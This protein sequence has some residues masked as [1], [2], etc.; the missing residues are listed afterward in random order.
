MR[1][2]STSVTNLKRN[3]IMWVL[4]A[5]FR[6]LIFSAAA[7]W[8][9]A[10]LSFYVNGLRDANLQS[11]KQFVYARGGAAANYI[12]HIDRT[13]KIIGFAALIVHVWRQ[14]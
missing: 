8:V 7:I 5:I 14:F 12:N 3:K 11:F 1:L 9:G 13:I 2:T 6:V 10:R 4:I